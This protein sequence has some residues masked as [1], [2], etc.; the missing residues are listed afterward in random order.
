MGKL[1]L[2]IHPQFETFGSWNWEAIGVVIAAILGIFTLLGLGITW[3]KNSL[4]KRYTHSL[5][6][7]EQIKS[8]SSNVTSILSEENQDN[9]K[10]HQAIDFLK[11]VDDL[12]GTLTE[13]PHQQIYLTEYSNTAY[14]LCNIIKKIDDFRFFYGIPDY[15][16]KESERLYQESTPKT[17]DKPCSRISEKM[18]LFLCIF[19][20]K[21]ERAR[22]DSLEKRTSW[23]RVFHSD[24]FNKPMSEDT[25]TTTF[26]P[27]TAKIVDYI[28]DYK[29]QADARM[30][31]R[32]QG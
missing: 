9:V 1:Y 13:K 5:F 4:D 29:K 26:G 3:R 18:L 7:L 16:N 23:E 11:S 2:I 32:E 17:F 20:D 25:P 6:Y 15:K 22:Y 14:T 30:I 19:I 8:Y 31:K 10:W 21:A 24:Y 28:I 12:K 27:S